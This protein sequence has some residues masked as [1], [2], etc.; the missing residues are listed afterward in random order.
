MLA[1]VS[2]ATFML[3]LDVTVVN[4][5]LPDIQRSLHSTFFDLEWVIDAYALTLAVFLL[6][7]GSLAD[8][9]GRRRVFLAGLVVFTG[10][11]LLCG[12]AATPLM[13]SLA[14][15][16]EGVGGA[17]MYAVSPA[18][19][20][21]NFHGK[22]RGI[23]FG[24]SGGIT[25][26]AV[27]IGPLIGGAIAAV[28]WR[29]IFL[30]NVPAGIAVIVV[31]TAKVAESRDPVRKRI[32]W[33]GLTLFS[34][35]LSMLVFALI[36]GEELGWTSKLILGLFAGSALLLTVFVGVERSRRDP[37]LDLSLFGNRS[38]NGLSIATLAANSAL[39]VAILFQVLYMQYV[40]RFS[41]FSTGVRYLPLT[42]A[43]F[44]AA[45]VAGTFAAQLP[46]R[47]LVGGGSVA[48]GIGLLAADGLTTGSRWTD[49]LPGMVLAG[50]G[51]GVFNPA[52]ATAAVDVAP[53]EQAGMSSGISET[54][55]QGGVALGVAA[56]GS[57]AHSQIRDTFSTVISTGGFTVSQV[58]QL[59]ELTSSGR[60]T[61]AAS[62][63][64][65]SLRPAVAA[66]ANQ[67]FI[68]GA[69]VVMRFGGYLAIVGGILGLLLIRKR[70][71][72]NRTG[73]EFENNRTKS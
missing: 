49:L 9:V 10:A 69:D 52:R 36:R 33:P 50:F 35:A 65:P 24:I 53:L 60:L 62:M 63:V 2:A 6:T 23:A 68:Q 45:A 11:S 67:A 27:A 66:A 48:L 61:E 38:F 47:L 1:G 41:A 59:A 44:L 71:F 46:F 21:A 31:I 70:D 43:V 13:L 40:L 51:M 12:L 18:L 57:A 4:V 14:R 30:L 32:D 34:A 28:S 22:Q 39:N 73:I 20:A 64:A 16:L 54:F 37:M 42:L 29:W 3:L 58:R 56:L 15:G 72:Q 5:A 55:Q 17:V 25:G 19:I 8:R 26:L 7:A